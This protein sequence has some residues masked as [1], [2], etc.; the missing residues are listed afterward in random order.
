LPSVV[1]PMFPSDAYGKRVVFPT[2]PSTRRDI[3]ME[4][5]ATRDAVLAQILAKREGRQYEKDEKVKEE[6]DFLSQIKNSLELA[7]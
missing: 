3:Q 5:D 2:D 6:I 1:S 4:V 7:S